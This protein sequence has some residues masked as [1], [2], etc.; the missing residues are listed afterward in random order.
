MGKSLSAFY[1]EGASVLTHP[2]CLR[3]G[4]TLVYETSFFLTG[5]LG[6][7]SQLKMKW[8]LVKF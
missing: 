7:D 3:D 2:L 1:K 4:A 6:P 8:A 5:E